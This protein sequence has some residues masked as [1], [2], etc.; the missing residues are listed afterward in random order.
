ML[1]RKIEDNHKRKTCLNHDNLFNR[2]ITIL[3]GD[4][5]GVTHG[6]HSGQRHKNDTEMLQYLVV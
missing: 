5:E 4:N 3:K 2:Y 6:H 1:I